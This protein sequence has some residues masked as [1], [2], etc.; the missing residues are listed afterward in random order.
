MAKAA[1]AAASGTADVKPA[2]PKKVP[3]PAFGG[4]H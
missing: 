3:P 4:P 2:V 1:P